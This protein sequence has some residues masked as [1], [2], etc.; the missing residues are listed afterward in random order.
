MP[1]TRESLPSN[2]YELLDVKSDASLREIKTAYR[3]KCREF[4]PDK[5]GGKTEDKMKALNQ[6]YESL[7]QT[8][9]EPNSVDDENNKKRRK[10]SSGYD[11]TKSTRFFSQQNS[12]DT[13]LKIEGWRLS[14]NSINLF[15]RHQK[16]GCSLISIFKIFSPTIVLPINNNEAL[17][18]S[19]KEKLSPYVPNSARWLYIDHSIELDFGLPSSKT[20]QLR[21]MDI[22]FETYAVPSAFR[23][24]VKDKMLLTE[25]TDLLSNRVVTSFAELAGLQ[26]NKHQ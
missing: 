8:V 15:I 18:K 17:F 19:L 21:V 3:N 7:M 13:E 25:N 1:S 11:H 5:N 16:F 10:T 4:H 2:P 20:S 12:Q 14:C 6:A 26:M 24:Y 23:E 9:S 22:I